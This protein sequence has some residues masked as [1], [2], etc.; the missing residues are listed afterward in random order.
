M[1]AKVLIEEVGNE[2]GFCLV[3]QSC[4]TEDSQFK[5][6]VRDAGEVMSSQSIA[7]GLRSLA[8]WIEYR[9]AKPGQINRVQEAIDKVRELEK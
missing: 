1:R 5:I 7:N 8:D 6:A 2:V 4:W 9:E 3:I